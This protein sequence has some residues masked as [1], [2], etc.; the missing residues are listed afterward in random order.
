M[1]FLVWHHITILSSWT[2]W[3]N[4]VQGSAFCEAWGHFRIIYP[5]PLQQENKLSLRHCACGSEG[6]VLTTSPS[7]ST[8]IF[9][10]LTIS[11]I[12][13]KQ[14]FIVSR[15][16]EEEGEVYHAIVETYFNPD[17]TIA[18]FCPSRAYRHKISRMDPDSCRCQW[19]SQDVW[20]GEEAIDWI[21]PLWWVP[22]QKRTPWC[23][24]NLETNYISPSFS[25]TASNPVTPF[26]N[27]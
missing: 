5:H 11:F 4:S 14:N 1:L 19:V 6:G 20:W 18:D 9:W 17:S 26:R 23:S 15:R 22:R 3:E 13:T 10:C 25:P 12:K 16:V 24:S 7:S 8:S 2:N 21:L 27:Y